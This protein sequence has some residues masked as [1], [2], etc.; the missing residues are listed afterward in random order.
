MLDAYFKL[1]RYLFILSFLTVIV[2]D[3]GCVLILLHRA[4]CSVSSDVS[5]EKHQSDGLV[6][7][8]AEVT[9]RTRLP[10]TKGHGTQT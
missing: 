4:V 7:V 3:D 1:S 10:V 6:Y 5:E 8:D 2:L 9:T